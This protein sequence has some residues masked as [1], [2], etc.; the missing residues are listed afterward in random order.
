M[1]KQTESLY[2]I[3][4]SR[5]VCNKILKK[6]NPTKEDAIDFL[7]NLHLVLE[8]SLNMFF[9]V[10][11]IHNRC[12]AFGLKKSEDLDEISFLHKITMFINSINFNDVKNENRFDKAEIKKHYEIIS[13]I[14]VFNFYRNKIIHGSMLGDIDGKKSALLK[15]LSKPKECIL[16]QLDLFKEIMD[17]V[18]YF[19]QLSRFACSDENGVCEKTSNFEGYFLDSDFLD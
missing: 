2:V 9:R 16:F 18:N 10:K 5:K 11:L 7:I 19:S 14:K 3:Q 15:K 8:C 13:K 4:S 17:G 1:V 12:E 6:E